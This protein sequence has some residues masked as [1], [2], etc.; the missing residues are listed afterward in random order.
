MTRMQDPRPDVNGKSCLRIVAGVYTV[1]S[2]LCLDPDRVHTRIIKAVEPR[3]YNRVQRVVDNIYS[4][5][6]YHTYIYSLVV[7]QAL[8]KY[9]QI[10][11]T[12]WEF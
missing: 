5:S 2:L 9:P 7:L 6:S 8:H 11:T 1:Y 10:G 4:P 12:C 3:W